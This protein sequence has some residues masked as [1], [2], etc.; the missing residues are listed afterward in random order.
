MS[1]ARSELSRG[2][3][4]AHDL[5][6]GHGALDLSLAVLG[7][8]HTRGPGQ[9]PGGAWRAAATAEARHRLSER[10]AAY[11]IGEL[12]FKPGQGVDARAGVA[13]GARW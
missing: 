1:S 4:S 10:W 7:V 9:R 5:R 13:L 11:A 3:T 2:L 8:P 6:P 12:G